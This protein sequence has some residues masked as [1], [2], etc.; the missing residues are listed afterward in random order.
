MHWWWLSGIS[1]E[2]WLLTL[3]CIFMDTSTSVLFGCHLFT[4]LQDL[5]A[6]SQANSNCSLAQN[7]NKSSGYLQEFLIIHWTKHWLNLTSFYSDKKDHK[8]Y[9]TCVLL[10]STRFSGFFRSAII[11]IRGEISTKNATTDASD[12][13]S[14]ELLQDT[15]EFTRC[16]Y[17]EDAAPMRISK[18]TTWHH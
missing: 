8:D 5:R 7:W 6:L 3:I 17:L 15:E 4:A 9:I 11:S 18:L 14:K 16:E 2:L 13:G 1:L 10:N 12:I